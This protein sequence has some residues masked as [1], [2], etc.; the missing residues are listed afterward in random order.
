MSPETPAYQPDFTRRLVGV[1]FTDIVGYSAKASRDELETFHLVQEHNRIL[2]EVI[3]AHKGEIVKTIGDAVMGRFQSVVRAVECALEMQKAL[4]EFNVGKDEQDQLHIRIG[5]HAGDV[6]QTADS[7]L[8]GHDVNIAARLEPLASP[9]SVIITDI[10]YSLIRGKSNFSFDLLGDFQLKNIPTPVRLYSVGFLDTPHLHKPDEQTDG[11]SDSTQD[12]VSHYRL[13][14]KIGAG[15]MG[16]V[17][18][19]EDLHLER[20]V[21]LKFLPHH[22]AQE[23]TDKARFIQEARTAARLSHANIAQVYEIGE[24]KGRLFIVM[25]YVNGG[26]LRDRLAQAE[27]RSLPLEEVLS[28]VHQSAAGLAEAHKQGIIHRDIKP[29]NLMLTE[30]GQVKITDFGLARFETTTRLTA[31]GATLGTVNFMSPEQVVGKNVDHRS[32]LFSLGVT[33]Y[34]LLT[35][36]RAFEGEDASAIF[37]AILNAEFESIHRF[38]KS[39]PSGVEEIVAKLLEKDPACRYQS[40]E[41]VQTD[42]LRLSTRK[43]ASSVTVKGRGSLISRMKATS[44]PSSALRFLLIVGFIGLIVLIVRLVS[45][46]SSVKTYSG[47]LGSGSLESPIDE[48]YFNIYRLK[49]RAGEHITVNMVS[50]DFDTYL[51]VRSPTGKKAENNDYEGST[52]LSRVEMD[53]TESGTWEITASSH[54]RRATGSY[55]VTITLSGALDSTTD[56]SRIERGTLAEG[57]ETLSTGEFQDT[58]TVNCSRGEKIVIDL[59]TSEFDPWLVVLTPGGEQFDNDDYEEDASRSLLSLDLTEDGT[60]TILVTSYEVGETGNYDLNIWIGSMGAAAS[61]PRVESGEL[62]DDDETLRSGE[63]MDSYTFEGIPGQHARLDL[64]SSDFDSYLLLKGPGE[65]N[66]WND[67]VDGIPGHS[68]IDLDLTEKGTYR[69]IVTSYEEGETGRYSLAI[70]IV[71]AGAEE[72]RQS[73]MQKIELGGKVSGRLETGDSRLESGLYQ[74]LYV[75]DGSAG[76]N[77]V[78]EMTSAD[79][80]SYLMLIFPSGEAVENDDVEEGVEDSRLELTLPESGRYQ[81]VATSYAGGLTGTYRITL[82]TG[83][84]TGPGTD[85]APITGTSRVYGIFV[86]IS[87]YPGEGFDLP[88]TADDARRVHQAMVQGAGMQSGDGLVIVDSDATVG[89][90]RDSFQRMGERVSENDLFIFFYSGH[91]GRLERSRYQPS[92]PDDLDETLNLYDGSITDDEMNDLC[93]LIPSRISLIII[94]ASFSGGFSNDVISVPGRMGLF[95]C[96]EDMTSSLAVKFKAGGFLAPFLADAVGEH[97]ADA[98]GDSQLTISE[99]SQYLDHRYRTSVRAGGIDDNIRTGGPQLG[100]QNLVANHGSIGPSVILLQLIQEDSGTGAPDV[101]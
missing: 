86:G 63:F 34:E 49:A 82:D 2:S 23:E 9:G 14:E 50:S 88:F 74:D 8:F 46:G 41:E 12:V 17:W 30:S 24:E 38:C 73:E 77:I 85:P 84:A 83:V 44:R 89:N 56:R 101:R 53:I 66:L 48:R 45:P 57:D 27:E 58:Y 71:G 97:L 18:L 40:A 90:L 4:G 32:D 100:Y 10:V 11:E 36:H 55:Q 75:F 95:S 99:L 42:I 31:S 43:A 70:D 29:D 87:D 7:D 61:G 51:S 65:I 93:N 35:G 54:E 96:E 22:V 16:E 33:F 59:R 20:K 76:Q 52:S 98:D 92:D 25:E 81:V 60:C 37:Y 15:G 78:L 39:L 6:L 94:D 28:W 72:G 26:S 69:V 3:T 62:S 13:I 1:M 91:G 67:D 79:F 5:V 19:A 47:T 21:A 64:S 80:D 68:I